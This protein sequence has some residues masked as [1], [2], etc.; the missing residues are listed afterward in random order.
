MI[1]KFFNKENILQMLKFGIVGLLNSGIS[2]LAF[3]FLSDLL[4]INDLISD[5]IS[6]ILGLIN[7]FILNKKWTFQTK[8]FSYKELF[9]FILFFG[10]SWGLQMGFYYLLKDYYHIQKIFLLS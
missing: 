5:I 4:K 7:S 3:I 9:L 8:K 10:I 2:A 6:Y 1:K